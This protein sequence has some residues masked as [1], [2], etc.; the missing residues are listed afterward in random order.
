MFMLLKV[1]LMCDVRHINIAR[2]ILTAVRILPSHLHST[3][4]SVETL[5]IKRQHQPGC[6]LPPSYSF[7]WCGHDTAGHNVTH[8]LL[9]SYMYYV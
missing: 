9:L 7:G 1:G 6:L 4:G 2:N 3:I 5:N 8:A